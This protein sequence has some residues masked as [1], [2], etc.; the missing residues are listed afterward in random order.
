MTDINVNNNFKNLA[1]LTTLP[2]KMRNSQ[3]N[4]CPWKALWR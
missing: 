3:I 2:I 4:R 1:V